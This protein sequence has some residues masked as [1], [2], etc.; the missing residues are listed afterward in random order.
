MPTRWRCADRYGNAVLIGLCGYARSGKDT[1]A[2]HLV[3]N[4]GFRRYAFAD[5]LR[6]ML[7]ALDPIV[8]QNDIRL[9]DV[10][11]EL[12]W[13][14]AKA[15]FPEVRELL[16]RL[17]TEAG[18]DILGEDIW[19]NRIDRQIAG[20]AV[21]TDV[22][23]MNEVAMVRRRNGSLWQVTRPGYDGANGH[24][25][26]QGIEKWAVDFV[27]NNDMGVRELREAVDYTLSC[28]DLT[29]R[30]YRISSSSLSS[31]SCSSSSA[32]GEPLPLVR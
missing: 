18:R 11:A 8:D 2:E 26:E 29:P 5:V 13:E 27:I 7:V 14:Q 24:R 28:C 19:V 6:E 21:I 31:S 15:A 30:S 25:S 16:Q 10:L 1:I 32:G 3:R 23:F 17:G 22:R 4:Y 9:S 20:D 12:N